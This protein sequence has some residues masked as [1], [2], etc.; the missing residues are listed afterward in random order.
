MSPIRY[1]LG[2]VLHKLIQIL[3]THRTIAAGSL[4]GGASFLCRQVFVMTV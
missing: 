1:A 3:S 4:S 2:P